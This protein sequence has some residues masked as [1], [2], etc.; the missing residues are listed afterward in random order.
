MSPHGIKYPRTPHL[1]WS[2]GATAEVFEVCPDVFGIGL[3]LSVNDNL[4]LGPWNK[5]TEARDP[6]DWSTTCNVYDY[7]AQSEALKGLK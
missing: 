5:D 2:P 7:V 1:P 4:F 6:L 3:Y